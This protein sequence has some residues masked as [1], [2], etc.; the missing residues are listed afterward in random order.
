MPSNE[1][2]MSSHHARR[3]TVGR[4]ASLVALTL[5]SAGCAKVP[6]PI[7]Y[8]ASVSGPNAANGKYAVVELVGATLK[9]DGK[10]VTVLSDASSKVA[11]SGQWTAPKATRLATMHGTYTLAVPGPCGDV[12]IPAQGPPPLWQNMDE[13][14]AAKSIKSRGYLWVALR[15]DMPAKRTVVIDRGAVTDEVLVGTIKVPPAVKRF[16]FW[17]GNCPNDVPVTVGGKPL[18]VLPS[19]AGP[20]LLTLERGIC[21]VSATASYGNAAAPSSTRLPADPVVALEKLPEYLL[22]GPPAAVNVARGSN[23]ALATYLVRTPCR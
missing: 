16:D 9:L 15:V 10:A 7:V 6:D 13:S 5:S 4:L 14:A 21:H 12:E 22:E 1:H 23:A 11:L 2:A 17:A 18:G 19:G 3:G 20:A 8:E